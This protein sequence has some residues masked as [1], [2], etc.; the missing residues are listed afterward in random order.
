MNF[1]RRLMLLFSALLAA[2]VIVVSSVISQTV[3]RAFERLDEERTKNLITLIQ[4]ELRN[5]GEEITRRLTAASASRDVIRLALDV[6]K[7]DADR[8]PYVDWA[9]AMARE[10][11]LEFLELVGGDGAIISSAHYP[12]R[13]GYHKD[14]LIQRGDWNEQAPFVEI[15]EMP[16][17]SAVALLVVRMVPTAFS[18]L[19]IVGGQRIDKGFLDSLA[20]PQGMRAMLYRSLGAPSRSYSPLETEPVKQVAAE[21]RRARQ[22]I[23][24]TIAEPFSPAMTVHG[25]PLVGRSKELV[26]VLVLTSVRRELWTVKWLIRGFGLAGA[27]GGIALG[28]ALAWWATSRVAQPVR[29]LADG[30]REVAAGRWNTSVEVD[31]TDEIG[32]LAKAFN[33]M[34][35]EL[36]SQRDRLVQVER[37]AAWRELARRLA[38]ELKNPL[39][40]LQ[41]TVENLQRARDLAPAQFDEVFRESTATLLAE[42][43]QL[44]AIIGRFSDFAKMPAPRFEKVRLAELL[45][46][47]LKLFEPQWEAPGRPAIRGE[48]RLED[49][50][51]TVEA[52]PDQLSRALRNL[53]LNAMDAMPSGGTITIRAARSGNDVLL[54]VAD[55]GE[56][57]TQEECERLFTPYYTTKQHGTGLGLAIVQSVVTDH[58]GRISV[59]SEPGKGTTFV[60]E[61]PEKR[62][63]V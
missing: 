37:V 60:M 19:Y 26:E 31:S 5:R 15:E 20:T 57:L 33:Q 2:T 56:G 41:I 63:A 23:S 9:P 21:V 51:I 27:L 59:K 29:L 4:R 42:L 17:E 13:F 8:A 49:D 58:G 40:P 22:E 39:F 38:H 1:R 55:T 36:V 54:S 53:I 32:E 24:H 45:P 50:A 14:W 62:N 52:D 35:A 48:I 47:I 11:G 44:K 6:S 61:L 3:T 16:E 18:N 25:I 12:A 46:P 43:S 34:T 10:Q 30:A 28:L 7:P